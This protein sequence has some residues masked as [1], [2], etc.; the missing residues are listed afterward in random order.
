MTKMIPKENSPYRKGA[1]FA[2][3]EVGD[4]IE[5]GDEYYNPIFDKWEP[6]QTDF[7]GYE[8]NPDESKPVRRK[9]TS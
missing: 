1:K 8:W 7:I 6:V 2:I 9:L 4:I 5:K 3:L